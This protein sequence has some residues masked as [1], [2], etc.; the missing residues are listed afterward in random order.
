MKIWNYLKPP[1]RLS[2]LLFICSMALTLATIAGYLLSPSIIRT[3]NLKTID[4]I[5]GA[6]R[7]P[8][9]SGR[10]LIVDI[11]E[12]SLARYGQWPWP[13]DLLSQLLQPIAAGGAASIG[14]DLILAEPDRTS[15]VRSRTIHTRESGATPDD[16]LS[17]AAANNDQSLSETLR[18]GPYI[19]GYEFLF[20]TSEESAATCRL[21]PVNAVWINGPAAAPPPTAL[22]HAS[23]AVCNQQLFTTAAAGSGFL[24]A[25][26]DADGLLRRVPQ[27]IQFADG[28]YPSLALAMLMHSTGSSQVGIRESPGGILL[29]FGNRQIPVDIHGNALINFGRRPAAIQR[30]SASD[31]LGG[32]AASACKEKL[33]LVG[34]TAAGLKH[35]YQTAAS[36][37]QTS[38]AVQ[39]VI[40]DRLL[41]GEVGIRSQEGFMIWEALAALLVSFP[42]F[43]AISRMAIISSALVSA[44]C[45]SVIWGGA[46]LLYRES[47]YLL[48]PLLP[49]FLILLNYTVLTILKTWKNLS[50]AHEDIQGTLLLL[51]S[52]E[53]N[54]NSIIKSVPDIIFRLDETGRITFISPA[55][56]KYVST[57]DHLIG[58]PI[59]DLV[60]PDDLPKAR[61]RL[62]EKRTG[63]RATYDLEI[64]L[65]LPHRQTEPVGYFSVSAEGI[66]ANDRPCPDEFIGTQ[67]I[68]RDITEQ[69]KLEERLLHAQKM[70]AVGNLAS[71]VAHDLNNVLVGLVTCPDLLLMELPE[72]S[73]LRSK[74]S[75]IQRS[76]QKA[77]AIVQD[78]LTLARRGIKNSSVL[79][80]NTI[81]TEYLASP[82]SASTLRL[83][84]AITIETDLAA[85]LMNMKGDRVHLSKVVMNLLNNAA[86]AMPTGGIIRVSTSNRFLE[87]EL[88]LYET[89]PPGE[90]ISLTVSDEG[91]GISG[92]DISRIFEP[93]FSKK[94]MARSGSGLGMTVIWA[95]IKDHEG[96]IDLQSRE[97]E[98][99]RFIL[100]LPVTRDLEI[101][102]GRRIGLEEYLGTEKVLIVDDVPE[103]RQIASSMLTKLGYIVT[104]VANGEAAVEYLQQNAVDIIILDMIMPGG[105][106][107]LET[108]QAIIKQWPEQKAIITSGYSESERVQALQQMGV[109]V[110]VQKPYTL[111][112]LGIAIRKELDS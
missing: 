105:M 111:E 70:E 7:T 34:T 72:D 8:P 39:A 108:F 109:E 36:P 76:G 25:T 77:A 73:P 49:T 13:R 47:S 96:F 54:L 18:N 79:N 106:D 42:L 20:D 63:E 99:T 59:F 14:L 44:T 22:F 94:S 29:T 81:I 43:F 53:K 90:Y 12:K 5:M 28:L 88:H 101:S 45:L 21:H 66:Y 32:S 95:T 52:S 112:K 19:L 82:E 40:L 102:T 48:S 58:R 61:Y 75:M 1:A 27:L 86:E 10:V 4:L 98:G 100:Y 16:S 83:H 26:P 78:L 11:D 60:A 80:L 110:Y 97:G 24:N 87:R 64:R 56:A 6:K 71:G 69:K 2:R 30:I 33:V 23:G 31:I 68:L 35:S 3:A 62:N 93:F 65:L 38:V 104:A 37:V 15:P 85:D 92:D 91:V 55:I 9:D 46:A 74:I 50:F 17:V 51:K 103:Q 107:G 57:P 84:S 41:S 89:I 67:G